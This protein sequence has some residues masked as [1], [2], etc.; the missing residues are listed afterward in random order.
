SDYEKVRALI[1]NDEIITS[2]VFCDEFRRLNISSDRLSRNEREVSMPETQSS[3][4]TNADNSIRF[5]LNAAN[6]EVTSTTTPAGTSETE[7]RIIERRKEANL[8]TIVEIERPMNVSLCYVLGCTASMSRHISAAKDSILQVTEFFKSINP[9]IKLRIGFYDYCDHCG[10]SSRL[11]KL[12]EE[13]RANLTT[14]KATGDGDAPEDVLGGLNAAITEMEWGDGTKILFHIG[15]CPPHGRR[16]TTLGDNYPDGDPNGLT[17]EC[18]LEKMQ[19][20]NIFY[21]FGKIMKKADNM[22]EVF[23]SIIDEFQIFELVSNDPLELINKFVAETTRSVNMSV[24]MFIT[25]TPYRRDINSIVPD[26]ERLLPRKGI[27]LCYYLPKNIEELQN[28]LYFEKENL[29]AKHFDFKIAPEPFAEGEE[30]Y[31]YFAI[32]TKCNPPRRVYK[33]NSVAGRKNIPLVNFVRVHLVRATMSSRMVYYSVEPELQDAEFRRFNS[34]SGFITEYRPVLEAFSHF[35][36]QH[37]D[38]YLVVCDLQ[39]VEHHTQSVL[40]D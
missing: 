2:S 9:C 14:V 17:A 24:N 5:E 15:D 40:I 39:R 19:S 32:N 3:T 30:R 11:Q 33:I 35:T 37:T 8:R 18:V 6:V 34:N 1:D 31:G 28:T 23:R 13:S 21:V 7:A 26:W 25:L 27:I 4:D 20:K 38:G 22:I 16:F 12:C 36:Y 29:I 10:G